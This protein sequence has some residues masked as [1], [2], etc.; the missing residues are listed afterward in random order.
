MYRY[1]KMSKED[2]GYE[3]GIHLPYGICS[4]LGDGKIS[5]SEIKQHIETALK[6]RK[7]QFDHVGVFSP[8]S[9]TVYGLDKKNYDKLEKV[10]HK[11]GSD[12]SRNYYEAD[13]ELEELHKRTSNSYTRTH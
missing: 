1:I 13:T 8:Y 2:F 7:I 12:I 6:E 11:L 5:E 10:W 9:F 4:L 3:Y